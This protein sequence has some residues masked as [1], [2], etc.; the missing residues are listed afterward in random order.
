MKGRKYCR[1]PWEISQA[2]PEL[3]SSGPQKGRKKAENSST[4]CQENR[5]DRS[6]DRPLSG[7]DRRSWD[8]EARRQLARDSIFEV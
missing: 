5:G 1:K 7:T 6:C 8:H 2:D 3:R 4:G